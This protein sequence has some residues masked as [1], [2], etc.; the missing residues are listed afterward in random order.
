MTEKDKDFL[1]GLAISAACHVLPVRKV[2]REPIAYSY[3][4]V[5]LPAL[6]EWD[7]E[8]YPYAFIYCAKPSDPTSTYVLYLAGSVREYENL[9]SVTGG[10]YSFIAGLPILKASATIGASAWSALEDYSSER[11]LGGVQSEYLWTN[12]D[13]HYGDVLAYAASDPI[14]V[15]E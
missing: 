15:Y 4:G 13:L 8:K 12:T 14:P 1:E 11:M 5:I 10:W 3:N 7:R 6:P 2:F 9:T